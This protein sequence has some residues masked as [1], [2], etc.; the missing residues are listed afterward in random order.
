MKNI[1]LK[2]ATWI[3]NRY[4]IDMDISSMV[5]FQGEKYAIV[6]ISVVKEI[7]CVDVLEITSYQ[8]LDSF[9]KK[10]AVDDKR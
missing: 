6:S 2:L 5:H 4:G 10:K 9:N 1:L 3:N 8:A 7:G